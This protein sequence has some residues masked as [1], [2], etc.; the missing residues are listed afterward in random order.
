MEDSAAR[1]IQLA[2]RIHRIR[3]CYLCEEPHRTF[4]RCCPSCMEYVREVEDANVE[5]RYKKGPRPEEIL[6]YCNDYFCSGEC[7][8]LDCGCVDICRGRCGLRPS[9]WD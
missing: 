3:Y 2:W 9:R 1:K 4:Y 5:W 7:G 6:H 8:E